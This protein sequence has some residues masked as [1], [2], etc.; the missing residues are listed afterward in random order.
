[1]LDN[2]KYDIIRM[3]VTVEI[4]NEED[5]NAVEDLRRA[6]L[7]KNMQYIHAD[8]SLQNQADEKMPTTF[9]RNEK[10]IG[11]NDVCPCGSGKKYKSCHGSLT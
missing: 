3:L 6:D 10:K 8:D 2:L 5:V 11:R 7:V 9:K 1:M 4:R